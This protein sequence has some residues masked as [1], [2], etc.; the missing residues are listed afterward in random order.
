MDKKTLNNIFN[1][2]DVHMTTEQT[3]VFLDELFTKPRKMT[4]E[5]WLKQKEIDRDMLDKHHFEIDPDWRD[6]ELDEY[7]RKNHGV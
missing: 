4:K 7:Y 5:F 1:K 3:D 2:P 6:Y